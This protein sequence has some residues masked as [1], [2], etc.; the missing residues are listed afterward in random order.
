RSQRDFLHDNTFHAPAK[1]GACRN[2][3]P[4][5]P[6]V[7]GFADEL[8]RMESKELDG[9]G[10]PTVLDV[11]RP[12]GVDEGVRHRA[13]AERLRE[14]ERRGPGGI[15]LARDEADR[16]TGLRLHE[17]RDGGDHRLLERGL[18]GADR[19]EGLGLAEAHLE[20]DA[21]AEADAVDARPLT[22][23]RDA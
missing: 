4:G 17:V 10:P 5:P 9:P 15:F 12:R 7:R 11:V 2:T 19:A 20:R 13:L 6:S 8:G 14:P 3:W 22:T 23:A 21:A 1:T 18:D 16:L